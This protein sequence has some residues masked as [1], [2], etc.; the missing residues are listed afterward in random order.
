MKLHI[1]VIVDTE[2][3]QHCPMCHSNNYYYPGLKTCVA[4]G[5]SL[6]NPSEANSTIPIPED[7]PFRVKEDNDIL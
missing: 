4:T 6:N 2:D 3:C 7:C 1:N 5:K